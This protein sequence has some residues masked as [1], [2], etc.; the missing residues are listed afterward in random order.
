[1]KDMIWLKKKVLKDPLN[2]YGIGVTITRKGIS[3]NHLSIYSFI[4]QIFIEYL[5]CAKHYVRHQGCSRKY[6]R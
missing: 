1:M 5:F 2:I 3:H 4:P 6:K